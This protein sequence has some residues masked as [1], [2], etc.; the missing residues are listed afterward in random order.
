[1]T[2]E[3][4]HIEHKRVEPKTRSIRIPREWLSKVTEG[5]RRR[6]KTPGLVIT[7]EAAQ[8]HEADWILLPLDVAKRLMDLQRMEDEG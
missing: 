7:F 5:A 2:S 1:M 6:A 4:L 3:T 8:G